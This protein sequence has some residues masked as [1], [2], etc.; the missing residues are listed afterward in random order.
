MYLQDETEKQKVSCV[1]SL[2]TH[3][4][5]FKDM[6]SMVGFDSAKDHRFPGIIRQKCKSLFKDHESDKIPID[7]INLLIRYV[8]VLSLHVD[9]FKTDPE[10]IAKDLRVSKVDLRKQFVNLGCK[11]ERDNTVLL[12]TLPVPLEFPQVMRK[13][14]R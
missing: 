6:N 7:K 3:F 2:L 10:D 5:K 14:R 4:V 8:L 11:F 1:L 9:K 12:A 13:R